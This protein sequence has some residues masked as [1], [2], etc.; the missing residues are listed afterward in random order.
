MSTIDERVVSMKFD[1]RQ[2]ESGVATSINT[3]NG[4]KKGLDL[5]GS[6]KGLESINN[7]ASKVNFNGMSS[8]IEAVKVKFSA[9]QVVAVA[10][11]SNIV[12]S[13]M[14]AGKNLISSLTLDP[15]ME[16]FKEY[17]TQMNSIQTIMANTS[18]KGTTLDQVKASLQ[19]LNTYS[20]KTIYNFTEMTRNIGTFTAAGVDLDKSTA[21]I[22]GIANLAAVSGSNSEQASS[23]MY[24]LSQA[25]AA[26]TVKLMDWNSVVNAGM[27][28]EVFQKS[29]MET[30]RTH[31]IAI[32]DMVKKEG[33]F[34]ETLQN[35][36]LSTDI[37]T[38]TLSKFTGDLT[39]EQ[40]KTMGYT[41]KQ[42]EGIM[43]MAQTANDAATKVKTISQLLDTL[44]EAVGSGWAQTWQTVFGDFEEAKSLFTN[45]SN[46]LG[47]MIS[48]SS[49]AR[50]QM[51]TGWKDLGG[52]T[53][54]IDA[55][56]TAFK[57]VMD[58]VKA[59]SGAFREVF[60]AT[61][62]AQ[63]FALTEGLKNLITNL[64][65]SSTNLTNL[66]STFKDYLQL[67]I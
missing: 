19:E 46:V 35:G 22:K 33:S 54:L 20:D 29:L 25:M 67:W 56:S 65:L 34:R 53:A 37:L 1:N 45:V 18:S 3:L 10:A 36:W 14:N 48:V 61:T 39:A 58:I 55:L 42:I 9:L 59:L 27:G 64:T 47:G 17:E 16:G 40:L 52:R 6:A 12:N 31:G 2:F 32:D 38:E 57:N 30:A 26:G 4:L 43:K 41:D 11:L 60:P 63:L 21:A 7:A 13:A 23:A 28:G 15:I 51:L 8:G 49:D 44:K 5:S 66:Q 24:Q 62:S 50:N